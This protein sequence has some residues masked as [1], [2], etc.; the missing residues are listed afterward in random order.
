MTE[1][2]ESERAELVALADKLQSS[3]DKRQ[4]PTWGDIGD[5]ASAVRRLAAPDQKPVA[6]RCRV[7]DIHGNP[8]P[9]WE[10]SD[11]AGSLGLREPLYLSPPPAAG[12]NEAIEACKKVAEKWL[13]S[14]MGGEVYVARSIVNAIEAIRHNAPPDS[15][16]GLPPIDESLHTPELIAELQKP[17][18]QLDAP[19]HGRADAGPTSAFEVIADHF[20]LKKKAALSK[21][22]P[23]AAKASAEARLRWALKEAQRFIASVSD[24]SPS[25]QRRRDSVWTLL[26]KAISVLPYTAKSEG[27]LNEQA[28]NPVRLPDGSGDLASAGG[29]ARDDI[30]DHH[31]QVGGNSPSDRT[32]DV[33]EGWTGQKCPY[34]KGTGENLSNPMNSGACNKCGGTGDEYAALSTHPHASDCDKQGER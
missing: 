34:C 14:F 13:E 27:G 18:M 16:V 8:L 33:M 32:S 26:D 29:I 5:A 7:T 4:L 19:D 6:W 28:R 9:G 31:R 2:S 22:A 10:Y 20:G 17:A 12:W 25:V 15:G 3:Y 11:D 30:K 23:A 21:P 1:R 24:I